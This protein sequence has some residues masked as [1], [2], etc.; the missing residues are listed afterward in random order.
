MWNS[1][2]IGSIGDTLDNIHCRSCCMCYNYMFDILNNILPFQEDIMYHK[3]Y[4]LLRGSITVLWVGIL[5]LRL[6]KWCL[7]APFRVS[8]TKSSPCLQNLHLYCWSWS[9]QQPRWL[10]DFQPKIANTYK[11]SLLNHHLM[12]RSTWH[13]LP[14]PKYLYCP[15]L[16]FI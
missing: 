2:R 6:S 11:L 9:L 15:Q 14:M 4:H 7:C 16:S 12:D 3:K 1:R 8:G 10:S 5:D 13:L